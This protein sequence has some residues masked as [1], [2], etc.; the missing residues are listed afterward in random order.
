M[1]PE[2]TPWE[3]GNRI[4]SPGTRSGSVPSSLVWVTT[5][6]VRKIPF[7]TRL[8]AWGSVREKRATVCK[9]VPIT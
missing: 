1:N 4:G 7:V 3:T 2:F 8:V 9:L 6:I 5:N